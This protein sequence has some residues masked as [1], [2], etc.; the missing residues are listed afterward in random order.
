MA[1]YGFNTRSELSF[2]NFDAAI[3]TTAENIVIKV[4]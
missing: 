1:L 4:R 3:G 2:E